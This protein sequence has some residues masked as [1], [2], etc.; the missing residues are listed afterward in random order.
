MIRKFRSALALIFLLVL[1]ACTDTGALAPGLTA[2][3]DT[4]GAQMDRFVAIGLI[5]ELRAA[6]GAGPVRLDEAL[7]VEAARAAARYARAGSI[8]AGRS[9]LGPIKVRLDAKNQAEEKVSAGYATFSD[10]F[11][12]WRGNSGD[13]EA[14]TAPWATRAGLGVHY[15]ASSR[16][17][18]YW[19]LVLAADE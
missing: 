13:T 16:F 4:P 10:T 6:N 5:N 11:S 19:V 17:G 9:A 2:R 7:N 12:G 8:G 14:L 3:L 18:T 1:A 15:D